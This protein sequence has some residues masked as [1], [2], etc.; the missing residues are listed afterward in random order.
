VG[1]CEGESR[2]KQQERA[3][4]V[5]QARHQKILEYIS[6]KEQASVAE[7]SRHFDVTEVTIRSDLRA[8]ANTG[9]V[10]RTHGGA[11]LIEERFRQEYT[12]QT[13]KNLNW[14]AKQK[15]GVAAAALV[16][17]TDS[18]LLDSSTTALAL[19]N[20]LEKRNG[21][22]DVTVIPTGI[23]TAIALMGSPHVQI[24]LPPGYLRHT[25]GSITGLPSQ[26]F[27]NGLIIQKAF[28][29]AWGV[30]RDNGLTDTHL[31]EIDLK[32]NIVGRVREIIVL[33][34][35]SKFHQS[36]IASYAS[37][38]QIST[39]VTDISAPAE[40]VKRMEQLGVRVIIA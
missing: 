25:S 36:G 12:F 27:F 23:W 30:S 28:L 26:D 10:A 38:D 11:R 35:G 39:L 3:S 5:L 29:G 6:A 7:L 8:L 19:A 18:I 9:R 37:M 16:S 22:K 32:K 20:A 21:L 34:D 1:C 14:S 33:A 15:I 2:Q 24:L 40:E 13:R 31:L 17:P 4:L